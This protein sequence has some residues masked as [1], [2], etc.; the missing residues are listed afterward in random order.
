MT[1]ILIFIVSISTI[2]RSCYY[3]VSDTNPAN[4]LTRPGTKTSLKDHLDSFLGGKHD[5]LLIKKQEP[6]YKKDATINYA[7]LIDKSKGERHEK[8]LISLKFFKN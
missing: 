1:G 6:Q 4:R 8:N 5:P 3:L 7:L 2:L